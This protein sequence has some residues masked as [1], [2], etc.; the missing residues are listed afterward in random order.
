MLLGVPALVQ[1]VI[2]LGGGEVLLGD[3]RPA[4]GHRGHEQVDV[5]PTQVSQ[6][7]RGEYLVRRADD[8]DQRGV[9]G[10]AA[11]VVDQDPGASGGDRGRLAMRV[12]EAGCAGLV[13][14]G[15]DTEAGLLESLKSQETLSPVGVGGHCDHHA[16][17]C[18]IDAPISELVFEVA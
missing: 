1:Q 12:L 11:Q 13:E 9:E 16:G 3:A 2:E 14:H 5:V 15:S 18:D 6:S 4:Q 7:V 8:V 10:A 17:A